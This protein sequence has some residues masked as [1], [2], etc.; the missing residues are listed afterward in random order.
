MTLFDKIKWVLGIV[1]VFLLVLTT[2][3]VDRQNFRVMKD[4][5]QAIHDDRLVAQDLLFSISREIWER[6]TAY[7]GPS[8][9]S[10]DYSGIDQSISRFASTTLTPQEGEL[11]SRLKA[12]LEELKRREAA[13]SRGEADSAEVKQSLGRVKEDLQRLSAI[14]MREGRRQMYSGK[15]AIDSA[16][17]FT[18]LEIGAL[19]ILAICV[20]VVILYSPAGNGK[21]AE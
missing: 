16:E 1:L 19:I 20:Q 12:G 9:T 5:L 3:L 15:E 17:F 2:N 18:Q 13:F 7:A 14:Q 8:P 6:E 10:P 21:M 4:S 11:F